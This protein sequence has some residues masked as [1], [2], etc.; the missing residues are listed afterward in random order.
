MA[1]YRKKQK[2][3][4]FIFFCEEMQQMIPELKGKK[5]PQVLPFSPLLHT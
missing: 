5:L 4:P 2:K 3:Q 1:S